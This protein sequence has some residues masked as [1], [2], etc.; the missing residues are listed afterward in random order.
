[1]NACRMLDTKP[2]DGFGDDPLAFLHRER[3]ERFVLEVPYA[4]PFVVIAYETFERRVASAGRISE[5]GAYG[6]N[7][8]SSAT[9]AKRRHCPDRDLT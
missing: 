5:F 4:Q 8:D 2:L 6:N 9:E 3:L 7:I 1:M